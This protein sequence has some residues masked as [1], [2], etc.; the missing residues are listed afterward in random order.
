MRAFVFSLCLT[1]TGTLSAA[2]SG[3]AH[4][5]GGNTPALRDLLPYADP[6][7]GVGGKGN[8]YPGATA[9]FG[10]IQWSPDTGPGRKMGGYS[11]DADLISGFSLDHLSGAGCV[12]AEDFSF[13]PVA[14]TVAHA[15]GGVRTAFA[16][17]FSHARETARPGYYAVS[18][19]SGVNVELT[20]T[21]RSGFGR[22][23]YPAGR[24]EAMTIN[25]ASTIW[26]AEAS[27]IHIDPAHRSVS[28]AVTGGHF[29]RLKAVGTVYFYAVFS[30]PFAHWATW[31]GNALTDGKTDGAGTQSGAVLTFAPTADHAVL[32][33]VALSY[34]SVANAR[35][36]VEVES[37]VAQF[38][39]GDFD[40]A[41]HAA[42][43][44][45]NRWLNRIELTGGTPDERKTFYSMFYHALLGPTVCSDVDGEYLGY[46]GR[47]HRIH[48]GQAQ[49]SNFS[50]WDVY[51][52]EC[53]FLALIAPRH[54]SD[55]AQS[56]L[57]DYR[58]G[59]TFP[60]WGV[61]SGDTGMM[62]GDP[63]APMIADFY[64]FG[65]HDFDTQA[66]LRG[67]LRAATDP[68][69]QAPRAKVHE[70]DGLADYLKLG[71]VSEPTA[72]SV[73]INLEYASADFALSQ[74]A[75]ALGDRPAARLCLAHAQNW[76]HLYNPATGYFQT[77][78]RDGS[79]APGFADDVEYYDHHR[80][81][82][83][84]TAAHYVWMVPF[85]LHGLAQ[86][87]GGRAAAARRLD[88]FLSVLNAGNHSRYA[89]LGNEPTLETPW[90]YC[91]LGQ[92]W[93]T[94]RTVRR[95]LTQLYSSGYTAYPGNDDLGEMSSWYLF[96]AL[97]MYPELPGSDVLVLGSPLFP[98]AVLHLAHG[99]L[100]IRGQGAAADAPYVQSLT[101]NGRPWTKPWLRFSELRHGAVLDYRL[102]ATPNR[103]WGRAPADAPPSFGP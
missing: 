57:R 56:L 98:Q 59:G 38:T 54:A 82:V 70:R 12:Y 77:R 37:P 2:G 50:G 27:D 79:W 102:A 61:P 68:G 24:P 103:S 40:A 73:G 19:G 29:C 4:A 21:T 60:R 62:V 93:K 95:A 45:W 52:S 34:V 10:M 58:D 92:P 33:K 63:S 26:G 96:G 55:M 17:P 32:A 13:M 65:A 94:Q 47:A 66:A 22:F 6:M 100:V 75:A 71:Y 90:I 87:M 36:N 89:D 1:L 42:S 3:P 76:R 49:Y 25:A 14:G 9:P 80:A 86:L 48:Q 72:G 53:Q 69:V 31:S 28:G 41:A 67:L 18:L 97:G 23:T 30:R 81:Y 8:T 44:R 16:S 101:V 43:D 88:T 46:D 78:R 15:P 64:A 51:R 39:S 85:D 35:A 91:F 99:D 83:E 5:A 84:G 7:C 11:L 74:F 20:T